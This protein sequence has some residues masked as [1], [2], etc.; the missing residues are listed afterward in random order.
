MNFDIYSMFNFCN[1]MDSN[2]HQIKSD[3]NILRENSQD[4]LI[5]QQEEDCVSEK[6]ENLISQQEGECVSEQEEYSIEDSI[7]YTEE[8][9]DYKIFEEQ[10][11][12]TKKLEQDISN[13]NDMVKTLNEEII[14]DGENLETISRNIDSSQR[15][16]EITNESLENIVILQDN[17]KKIIIGGALGIII[18]SC[19][20]TPIGIIIGLKTGIILIFSGPLLSGISGSLIGYCV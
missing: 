1:T 2:R 14:R 8:E 20:F 12:T 3:Q 15:N 18:G 5:L 19:I 10:L 7:F 17:K 11:K 4:N 16:V 9:F 13:I 6:A